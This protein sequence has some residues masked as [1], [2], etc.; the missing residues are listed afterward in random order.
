MC[1]FEDAWATVI[2]DHGKEWG[3][4]DHVPELC[5]EACSGNRMSD[6]WLAL[7]KCAQ[8]KP[9]ITFMEVS[10]NDAHFY[11]MADACMFHKYVWK[12]CGKHYEDDDPD[13]PE[14]GKFMSS[15][16]TFLY[17]TDF[18]FNQI[19]GS[20]SNRCAR[21]SSGSKATTQTP[22]TCGEGV[23]LLQEMTLV[24]LRL[25]MVNFSP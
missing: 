4:S 9:K 22:S 11:D 10:G 8:Y 2:K 17:Q 16:E 24:S 12:D 20:R 7:D 1:S 5:F 13:N 14:G 18:E 3:P 23:V 6:M 21:T 15:K 19:V 25:V